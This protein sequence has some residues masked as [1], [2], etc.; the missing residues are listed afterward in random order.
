[1][2]GLERVC[3]GGGG[4]EVAREMAQRVGGNQGCRAVQRAGCKARSSAVAG[5]KWRG[6]RARSWVGAK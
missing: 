1:M 5:G 6:R 4:L 3:K 2:G